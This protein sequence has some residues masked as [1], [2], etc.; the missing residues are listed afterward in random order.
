MTLSITKHIALIF[1]IFCLMSFSNILTNPK[2]GDA[3]DSLD[4]IS[5]Y[6]NGTMTHVAGRHVTSDGYNLGLKWQCVEFVKR[7]Y[8]EIY[9]HKMPD[10]YGHAKDFF[11]KN[12]GDVA[13][14]ASRGLMQFRNVRYE[15]PRKGDILIYDSYKHN[16]YGHIGIV[17]EVN[18]D[19]IIL[20]QQNVKKKTRQKLKLV[21]YNG[22][23]TVADF[24]VLGWL[25]KV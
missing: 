4:G 20:I 12:L 11:D 1:S 3:I 2:I 8:Y 14:N 21:E 13:Y 9:N 23:Y 19:H 10:S 16:P 22:I 25:R 7:Y 17:A 5:V 24:D 6:Y 15:K 18:P